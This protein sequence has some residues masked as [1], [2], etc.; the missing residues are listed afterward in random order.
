[1]NKF[2]VVIHLRNKHFQ[3]KTYHCNQCDFK[4]GYANGLKLH[5]MSHAGIRPYK[6]SACDFRT[7]KTDFVK[8]HIKNVHSDKTGVTVERVDLPFQIDSKK[9]KCED[10]DNDNSELEKYVVDLSL[11]ERKQGKQTNKTKKTNGK[12][13]NK[14]SE[15][16]AKRE[17]KT[18]LLKNI[19]DIS[20]TSKV[21]GKTVS[22]IMPNVG[23]SVAKTSL[24]RKKS[25]NEIPSSV[26][27]LIKTINIP[28][29][30]DRSEDVLT[31]YQ[32]SFCLTMYTSVSE[33]IEHVLNCKN[34]YGSEKQVTG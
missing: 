34:N 12:K 10:A 1:M 6:C 25:D 21:K 28:A 9:F 5:L 30:S 26:S 29:T 13:D 16:K 23:S 19:I 2:D 33:V 7:N 24:T 3:L 32:C 22:L 20:G 8:R 17:E 18:V 31:T 4:T 27:R 14:E 15:S 11:E